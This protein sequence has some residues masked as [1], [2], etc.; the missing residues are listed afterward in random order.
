MFQVTHQ[1]LNVLS[2]RH[3]GQLPCQTGKKIVKNTRNAVSRLF[4]GIYE[5]PLSVPVFCKNGFLSRDSFFLH[6]FALA[7]AK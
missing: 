4:I 3:K 5:N 7:V 6:H 2:I 1:K